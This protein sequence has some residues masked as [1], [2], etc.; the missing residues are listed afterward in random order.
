MKLGALAS[1]T[2]WVTARIPVNHAMVVVL[3]SMDGGRR[4]DV[5]VEYC[6][7]R[8]CSRARSSPA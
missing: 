4:L 1:A 2:V 3:P 8:Y 6:L 7:L 5:Y